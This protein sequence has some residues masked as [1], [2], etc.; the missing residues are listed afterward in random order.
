MITIYIIIF[1]NGAVCFYNNNINIFVYL[2]I[3]T[4]NNILY[5]SEYMSRDV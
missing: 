5:Y 4:C 1:I 2:P 3:L